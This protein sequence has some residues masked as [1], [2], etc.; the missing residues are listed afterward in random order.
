WLPTPRMPPTDAVLTIEPDPCFRICARTAAIPANTPVRF[1]ARTFANSSSPNSS[2]RFCRPSMPALLKKPSIEPNVLT[3]VST[4]FRSSSDFVTSAVTSSTRP[5]PAADSTCLRVSSR[6]S[7]LMSTR[8]RFAASCASRS[9]VACPST[10]PAPVM[11]TVLPVKRAM[12]EPLLVVRAGQGARK[13]EGRSAPPS[14]ATFNYTD[15][16]PRGAHGAAATP[17]TRRSAALGPAALGPAAL[18]PAAR[19]SAAAL[20][21]PL[22]LR[23]LDERADRGH[24]LLR[25]LSTLRTCGVRTLRSRDRLAERDGERPGLREARDRKSVV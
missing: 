4:Y 11:M 18:G 21:L 23:L 15:S 6:P 9:A 22:R 16:Y 7:A 24:D 17:R 2:V 3:A 10:E 5:A 1:T 14:S 8:T 13:P 25:E 19:A 20:R 12:W